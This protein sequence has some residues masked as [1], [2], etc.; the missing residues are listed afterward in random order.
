MPDT[1]WIAVV[2]QPRPD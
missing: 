2:K 1:V